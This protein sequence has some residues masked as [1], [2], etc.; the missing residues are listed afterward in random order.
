MSSCSRLLLGASLLTTLAASAGAAPALAAPTAVR[1]GNLLTVTGDAAANTIAAG[2]SS[3][4]ATVTAAGINDPDGGGA[5]C[6]VSGAVLSCSGVTVVQVDGAG[7]NDALTD[8]RPYVTPDQSPLALDMAGGAGDDSLEGG[9]LRNRF[10]A[11]P[12]AD[13]YRGGTAPVDPGSQFYKSFVSS[14]G[15]PSAIQLDDGNVDVYR[16][17]SS[18]TT[19]VSLSLDGVANDGAA[20]ELDNLFN[21]IEDVQ[22]GS[23]DDRL[24]AGGNAVRLTGG[25]G[26]DVITGSPQADDLYGGGDGGAQ[27]GTDSIAGGAGDDRL[28]PGDYAPD[29]GDPPG[30][31]G[32]DRLD[33]GLG[34][35]ELYDDRGADDL[36]GGPGRDRAY[37]SRSQPTDGGPVYFFADFPVT[38]SLDDQANDGVTGAGEGDNVHSDIEDLSTGNGADVITGSAASNAIESGAGND[39]VTAGPGADV[40]T[41]GPGEDTT[42]VQDGQSDVVDGGTGTD[43]ASVDLPGEDPASADVLTAVE[44]V[45]GAPLPRRFLASQLPSPPVVPKADTTP[46]AV[47]LSGLTTKVKAFLKT[48]RVSATVLTAEPASVSSQLT[49][50]GRLRAVGDLVLATKR[51]AAGTGARKLTLTVPKKQLATFKRRLRTKK[52]VKTGVSFGLTL[53]VTDAAG[54]VT[55]RTAKLRVRG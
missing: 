2:G 34:D 35:D 51:L 46:P 37:V 43:G 54:L 50:P 5:A 26:N 40:V 38:V 21:D 39:V 12:G 9:P 30:T 22:A 16:V 27:G 23:G 29:P 14:G 28:F 44:N 52:Q 20:G 53:T 19:P 33:G 8:T 7:G 3:N 6:T 31:P 47:A 41:L 17:P 48:G 42:S 24:S 36:F 4:A 25:R 45:T 13:T 15:D 11:E 18:S 10:D 49:T 1:S 32:P 55:T